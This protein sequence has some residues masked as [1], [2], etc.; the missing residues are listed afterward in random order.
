MDSSFTGLLTSTI[1]VPSDYREMGEVEEVKARWNRWV[2]A[3]GD[4]DDSGEE[5]ASL[6]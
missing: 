2:M 6:Q 5:H 3:K 4:E 1:V